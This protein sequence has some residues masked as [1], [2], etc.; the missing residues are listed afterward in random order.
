[1]EEGMPSLQQRTS[2][3]C[4][5]VNAIGTHRCRSCLVSF[6]G[7]SALSEL[8]WF[9]NEDNALVILYGKHQYVEVA[10]E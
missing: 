3:I 4:C 6:S 9:C 7:H 1:M 10:L 2:G 5:A 8:A